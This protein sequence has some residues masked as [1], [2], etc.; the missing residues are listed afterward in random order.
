MKNPELKNWALF[1]PILALATILALSS[2]Q[3]EV[4]IEEVSP[5]HN[6]VAELHILS[7]SKYIAPSIIEKFEK[8]FGTRILVTAYE[9]TD[10]LY[11]ISEAE[12]HSYD[13]IIS[14][15]YTTGELRK[16]NLITEIDQS[17]LKGTDSLMPQFTKLDSD[18]E[19]RFTLPYFWGST[20][21]AYRSDKI[22]NPEE[23]VS[24]IFSDE[25]KGKSAMLSDHMDRFAFAHLYRGVAINERS[26]EELTQSSVLLKSYVEDT[27]GVFVG[28][29]KIREGLKDGTYWAAQCYNGDAAMIA[30]VDPNIKYFTPKEGAALWLDV[31]S[32]TTESRN[33]GDAHQF[34]NFLLRPEITAE[35]ADWACYAPAHSDAIPLIS[36][37]RRNDRAIFPDAETLTKCDFIEPPT[38]EEAK[39]MSK[40]SR[41][42]YKN[43]GTGVQIE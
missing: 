23:S 24:L 29:E 40:L 6:T 27:R 22:S 26:K 34:M 36:E 33:R 30:E 15:S 2:C 10:Q 7:W 21:V 28:D 35:N 8:E 13:L 3:E 9:N 31:I 18:P 32:I 41:Q 37:K 12:N 4:V 19:N 38:P 5:E 25:V 39:R 43:A 14:P 11:A 1:R 42:Y 16:K 20:I 17:V